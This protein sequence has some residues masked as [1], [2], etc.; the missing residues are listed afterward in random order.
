MVWGGFFLICF[1]WGVEEMKTD[2]TWGPLAI[3]LTQT[4]VEVTE[5]PFTIAQFQNVLNDDL[6]DD[7]CATFPTADERWNLSKG[8]DSKAYISSVG[9]NAENFHDVVP[10]T[11]AWKVFIE[12]VSSQ[13][14]WSDVGAL[15]HPMMLQHKKAGLLSPT[16]PEF[17]VDAIDER[18]RFLDLLRRIG[19]P[20]LQFS[21]MSPNDSNTPHS[22]HWQKLVNIITYYPTPGWKEEFG[23]GTV[24]LRAKKDL[25]SLPWFHPTMNR[26]PVSCRKEFGV[27]MEI[28]KRVHYQ[29][30]C[31][32]L[33]CKTTNSFHAV[34]PVKCPEPLARRAFNM[35]L[36]IPSF[37]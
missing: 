11:S 34:E 32:V 14:F 20:H 15:I 7:L 28:F 3:R 8:G 19:R 31:W 5:Q 18:A 36:T 21:Y 9:Q 30:N 10:T 33:F 13:D 4:N 17:L 25:T 29:R 26:V 22:D 27:D 23:G 2:A 24:F 6:Y 37:L 35:A 12:A 16:L 1:G